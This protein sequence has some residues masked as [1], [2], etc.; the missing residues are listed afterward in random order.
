MYVYD[1]RGGIVCCMIC[2]VDLREIGGGYMALSRFTAGTA[3]VPSCNSGYGQEMTLFQL[4]FQVLFYLV[5]L[6]ACYVYQLQD[7]LVLPR[8][9]AVLLY[10]H[11]FRHSRRGGLIQGGRQRPTDSSHSYSTFKIAE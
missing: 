8:T 3:E 6:C 11:L 2:V 5:T 4:H 9:H 1:E 10:V 7:D